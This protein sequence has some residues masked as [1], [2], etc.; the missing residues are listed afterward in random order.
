[1]IVIA[2]IDKP[3]TKSKLF[4]CKK[5]DKLKVVTVRDNVLIVEHNNDKFSININDTD[6]DIRTSIKEIRRP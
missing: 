2:K 1:M 5:G 4:Y 6:Y 3:I